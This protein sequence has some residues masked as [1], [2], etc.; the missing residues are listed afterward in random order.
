MKKAE[1]TCDACNEDLTETSGS[2]RFRLVLSS[3]AVRF[4]GNTM[5]LAIVYPPIERSHHFCNLKCL[6]EWVNKT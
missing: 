1:I 2:P 6:S 3:E 4:I 5:T